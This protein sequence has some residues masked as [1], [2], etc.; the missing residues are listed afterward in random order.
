MGD[1][2]FLIISRDSE[3]G[4]DL[5]STISDFA[6]F[7]C[8]SVCNTYDESINMILSK[9]PSL[10]FIDVDIQGRVGNPFALANELHLYLDKVPIFVAISSSK[11]FAYEVIKNGFFDYLLRSNLEIEL[12]KCFKKFE[13]D[14]KWKN[15]EKLCLKS[16][17]DYQFLD[18]DEIIFLKADN[19]TTDL[20]LF[21]NRTT[22][23]FKTLKYYEE[24]LPKQ[25]IRV[26]HSYIINSHQISRINFAKLEIYLKNYDTSV[27][28]SKS[29]KYRVEEIRKDMDTNSLCVKT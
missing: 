22:T 10:V 28:F 17:S 7:S 1:T 4:E 8:L 2:L 12:R 27:P 16:Y 13:K 9:L 5:L 3:F 21:G 19:N 26:H 15:L 24:S 11:K 25:F 29:Y 23:G 14:L 18:L 6:G 20:F